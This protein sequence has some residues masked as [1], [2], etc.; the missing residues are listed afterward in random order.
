M[1][2]ITRQRTGANTRW[3][4]F[5]QRLNRVSNVA[6]ILC[7]IDCIVFPLLLTVLPL[8]S[9]FYTGGAT[10]WIHKASHAC[11]LWFVGPVGGLAVLSN[12]LEHQRL[13]VGLWGFTGIALILL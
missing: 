8:I 11:A 10:V 12:W 13:Y 5:L 6:S 3:G 2:P 1:V 7:A 4:I 9:A